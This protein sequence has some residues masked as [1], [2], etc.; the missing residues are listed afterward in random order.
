MS[1]QSLPSCDL[2]KLNKIITNSF[3]DYWKARKIISQEQM[4]ITINGR[5]QVN[6]FTVILKNIC[7]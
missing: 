4:I 2:G 3:R 7:V 1:H 6:P 5:Y